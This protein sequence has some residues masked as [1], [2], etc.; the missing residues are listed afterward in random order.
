MW[1][2]FSVFSGRAWERAL[3]RPG[4]PLGGGDATDEPRREEEEDEEAWRS[5]EAGAQEQQRWRRRQK[6]AQQEGRQ[7]PMAAVARVLLGN[8]RAHMLDWFRE[9]LALALAAVLPPGAAP[10]GPPPLVEAAAMGDYSKLRWVLFEHVAVLQDRYP[11]AQ[12]PGSGAALEARRRQ[13]AA[14]GGGGG[15]LASEGRTGFASRAAAVAFRAAA[16]KR[17]GWP[18]AAS[19]GG[20]G[21]GG[22]N[23]SGEGRCPV[24]SSSGSGRGCSA[25]PTALTAGR[26]GEATAKG[27]VDAAAAAAAATSLPR[28]VTVMLDHDSY[29]PVTNHGALVEALEDV[30]VPLGFEVSPDRIFK[31]KCWR[32]GTP[33]SAAGRSLSPRACSPTRPA[34]SPCTGAPSAPPPQVRVVSLTM[35]APF[36]SHLATMA[37]TGLLVARHGPILASTVLLP[38]GVLDGGAGGL[39]GPGLSVAGAAAEP[40]GSSAQLRSLGDV[41]PVPHQED[42]MFPRNLPPP[43]SPT[44]PT[45]PCRA[46]ATP[47]RRR[48]IGAPALQMGL[49]QHEHLVQKHDSHSGR[50]APLG[51]ASAGRKVVQVRRPGPW[52]G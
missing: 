14:E 42:L 3:Q 5:E 46:H 11:L 23:G 15:L 24:H 22:G 18:L 28:L 36:V 13:A 27:E 38:P 8:L 44:H 35:E 49:A 32:V 39:P 52:Q 29:P 19:A 10:G 4:E 6:S 2:A 16:Y 51:V 20:A 45:A 7:R 9:T 1:P 41:A 50:P 21:G 31:G 47:P 40:A 12:A 33:C 26:K 37:E 25:R 48:R 43:P 17:A 34:A 30:A